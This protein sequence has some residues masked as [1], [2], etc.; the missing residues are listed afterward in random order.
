MFLCNFQ[1]PSCWSVFVRIKVDSFMLHDELYINTIKLSSRPE[2]VPDDIPI[3]G[4][5]CPS[6][7]A[8]VWST[9]ADIGGH[10]TGTLCRD[11][12]LHPHHRLSVGRHHVGLIVDQEF[13]VT[14]PSLTHLPV[15][16]V[17][18]NHSNGGSRVLLELQNQDI[19]FSE[20]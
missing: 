9:G 2:S 10:S 7:Q 1:R 16:H 8:V 11:P 14:S 4:L 5:T 12:G 18:S 15:T 13:V 19:S 6:V 17:Y 3:V 20:K